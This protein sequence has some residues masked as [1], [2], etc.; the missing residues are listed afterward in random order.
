ME[1][2]DANPY[3]RE[4]ITEDVLKEWQKL[5]DGTAEI[6]CVPRG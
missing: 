4:K 5:L 2:M 6:L 3:N 1:N